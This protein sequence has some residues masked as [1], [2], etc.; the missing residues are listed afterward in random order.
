[1]R[2]KGAVYKT[3]P[4]MRVKGQ[5]TRHVYHM[6]ISTHYFYIQN[7]NDIISITNGKYLIHK[8]IELPVSIFAEKSNNIVEDSYFFRY[9]LIV[10]MILYVGGHISTGIAVYNECSSSP[11][12]N[13]GTCIDGYNNYTCACPNRYFGTTC[14]NPYQ[15]SCKYDVRHSKSV[16]VSWQSDVWDR[17]K[18]SMEVR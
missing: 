7:N 16:D 11:C 8:K 6:S 5:W 1:M 15:V 10:W 12:L 13:G 4:P 17:E 14:E 9:C 2:V 3:R 18:V